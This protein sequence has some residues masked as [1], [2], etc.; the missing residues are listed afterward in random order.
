MVEGGARD[1]AGVLYEDSSYVVAHPCDFD[2]NQSAENDP[3]RKAAEQRM[4]DH[5]ALRTAWH[6]DLATC[7][8]GRK[9]DLYLRSDGPNSSSPYTTHAPVNDAETGANEETAQWS[10]VDSPHFD[11]KDVIATVM[12]YYL[13][14]VD[15]HVKGAVILIPDKARALRRQR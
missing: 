12:L 2:A 11:T 9:L 4:A 1:V 14:C 5:L 6:R 3:V 7:P 10:D 15:V 8:L 13:R